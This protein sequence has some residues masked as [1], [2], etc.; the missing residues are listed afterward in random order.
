VQKLTKNLI[1]SS[2]VERV[3]GQEGLGCGR[4]THAAVERLLPGGNPSRVQLNSEQITIEP[5]N[6]TCCAS[7][8][9]RVLRTVHECQLDILLA[10]AGKEHLDERQSFAG[11]ARPM[12]E[13]HEILLDFQ[14][15][16]LLRLPENLSELASR[17]TVLQ[18]RVAGIE[19]GRIWRA[20]EKS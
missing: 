2:A 13:R 3:R 9:G 5:G 4:P 18:R 15:P 12:V 7:M 17:Q 11:A 19:T 6:K 10:G 8:L 20:I 1:D 14:I 16:M